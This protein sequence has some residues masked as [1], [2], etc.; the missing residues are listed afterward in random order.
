MPIMFIGVPAMLAEIWTICAEAS[1]SITD[2][3]EISAEVS[4][5]FAEV[6]AMLAEAA[7]TFFEVSLMLAGIPVKLPGYK[8]VIRVDYIGERNYTR[9]VLE[10]TIRGAAYR[11]AQGGTYGIR[12]WLPD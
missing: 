2:G 4:I 5:T 11:A 6:R 8:I 12:P 3:S 1:A 9:T 10:V 7:A